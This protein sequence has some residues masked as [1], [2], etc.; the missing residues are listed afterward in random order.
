MT[1]TALFVFS[2]GWFC[3]IQFA[4]SGSLSGKAVNVSGRVLVR[5]EDASQPDLKLLKSGDTITEGT[6][7][8]TS[9]VGNAKLLLNDKTV[10]DIGPS[11]LFKVHE[12]QLKAGEDRNVNMSMGYGKIRA[13]VNIP[14]GP[15]G[16]FTIKTRTATMGVRGTEFVV[17]TDLGAT[18]PPP[19]PP[20]DAKPGAPGEP[21]PPAKAA[22]STEG[23]TQITVIQ[24][25]LEV[26]TEQPTQ[27]TAT[28]EVKKAEPIQLTEGTQLT[29]APILPQKEETTGATREI[30]Q[31]GPKIVKLSTE[32]L[33]IVQKES[34]QEDRT[35]VQAVVVDTSQDKGSGLA[36]LQAISTSF[37]VPSEFVPTVQTMGLPGTFGPDLGIRDQNLDRTTGS[38]ITIRIQFN[39]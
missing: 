14:V 35:F 25:K 30:A 21:S 1:K 24:G 6:V 16:K 32:E 20:Q 4:F 23:Q 37:T 5:N 34:K 7:L 36:T 39:K 10:L 17:T 3:S 9:S 31:E 22:T 33:K 29:T 18:P 12:F 8:N 2:L 38:P 13:A 27:P 28:G 19:P 11:T 15:R 26:T